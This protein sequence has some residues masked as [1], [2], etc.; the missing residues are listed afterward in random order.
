MIF[1]ECED[2]RCVLEA[3]VSIGVRKVILGRHV[4]NA[5]SEIALEHGFRSWTIVL[6]QT[7]AARFDTVTTLE[8]FFV[9]VQVRFDVGIL[10]DARVVPVLV[11]WIDRNIAVPLC[12]PAPRELAADD[13]VEEFFFQFVFLCV[14]LRNDE[15]F[16]GI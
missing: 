10:R 12:L 8:R 11:V 14:V 5:D 9:F 7:L 16:V 4:R 15:C 6:V 13:G 3:V 1:R 2:V